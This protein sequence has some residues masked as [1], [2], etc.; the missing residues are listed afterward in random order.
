M[1]RVVPAIFLVFLFQL[2]LLGPAFGLTLPESFFPINK[3]K[4][5]NSELLSVKE[6][7]SKRSEFSTVWLTK[8]RENGKVRGGPLHSVDTGTVLQ[9]RNR[10]TSG[11]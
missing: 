3:K 7:V 6:D 2:S 8:V 10:G 9:R 1:R 4:S 5:T 11:I